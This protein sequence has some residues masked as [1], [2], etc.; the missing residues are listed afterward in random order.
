MAYQKSQNVKG[1]EKFRKYLTQILYFSLSKM[2]KWNLNLKISEEIGNIKVLKV[3][4]VI[5]DLPEY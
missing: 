4:Q 1:W 5:N 3:S 2:F